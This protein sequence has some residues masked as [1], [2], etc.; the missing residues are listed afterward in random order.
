MRAHWLYL[1]YVVRH[2]WYVLLA[3]LWLGVPLRQLLV[4]DWS[5]LTPGEWFPY[6]AFF[7]GPKEMIEH[8]DGKLG[9][10]HTPGTHAAFDAAWNHHQKVNPHHWQYWVL[11]KDDGGTLALP[12]PRPFYLEMV[13]DWRGAGRAQNTPDTLAW[14][15]ANRDKMVLHEATRWEV[16]RLLGYGP[17]DKC[18]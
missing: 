6:V 9:Y 4:H 14:Y 15:K 12:M 13:A 17:K 11:L 8:K 18:A 5:K 2:K 7:Y 3:G 1:K 16:E 10:M